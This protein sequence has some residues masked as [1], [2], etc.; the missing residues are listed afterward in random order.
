VAS[1][2]LMSVTCG[3]N[4]LSTGNYN[5]LFGAARSGHLPALRCLLKFRA[6]IN[7][8]SC[9]G[10]TALMTAALHKHA[11]VVVWL[12]K[13]GADPQQAV[14]VRGTDMITAAVLFREVGAS[15]EQTAYL[16]TK[17]HCS[18]PGCSGA[19]LSSRSARA[20]GRRGT[21]AREQCTCGLA[22]WPV[23]EADCK[24]WRAELKAAEERSRSLEGLIIKGCCCMAPFCG[25]TG[26]DDRSMFI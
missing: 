9:V 1:P 7:Y 4:Q 3:R 17:T 19:G 5:S 24:R 11:K 26:L 22:Q 6:E 2:L 12:V 18:N 20:A 21:A 8:A 16:E 23:H 25:I 13:A 15:A 14:Q 10:T